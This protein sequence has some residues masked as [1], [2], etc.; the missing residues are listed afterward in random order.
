MLKKYIYKF[1]NLIGWAQ[2]KISNKQFIFLSSVL[3]GILAAFAVIVLKTFAHWVFLFATH[4]TSN[5]SVFKYGYIKV[6]LPIIGI[7]LTVFVI[8]RVLG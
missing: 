4:L 6:L 5:T 8:K 7:L 2:D 1:E 3:V